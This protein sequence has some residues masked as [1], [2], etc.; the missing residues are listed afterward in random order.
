MELIRKHISLEFKSENGFAE[1]PEEKVEASTYSPEAGATR[2]FH[3]ICEV[4]TS[5]PAFERTCHICGG[6]GHFPRN[7]KN[8]ICH[9]CRQ[10]GHFSRECIAQ[11]AVIHCNLCGGSGH[12]AV[13]CTNMKCRRC[14]LRGHMAK[15]C[16]KNGNSYPHP[17]SSVITNTS[18]LAR[19]DVELRSN[20]EVR[21]KG[22]EAGGKSGSG[23]RRRER[24]G[25]LLVYTECT[26]SGAPS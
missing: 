20:V 19:T 17:K 5:P 12:R 3:L 13:Q 8:L 24:G 22:V 11:A 6:T 14:G 1:S 23:G 21:G 4:N 10:V 16:K 18:T 15:D 26:F 2:L 7:C 9:R 25:N